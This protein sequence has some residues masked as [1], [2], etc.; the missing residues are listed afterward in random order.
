MCIVRMIWNFYRFV[1]S[2]FNSSMTF[3][4]VSKSYT[5]R[6]RPLSN[7]ECNRAVPILGTLLFLL[8]S[9]YTDIC[10][11]LSIRLKC[12]LTI[13]KVR[14]NTSKWRICGSVNISL[15]R[16]TFL[17]EIREWWNLSVLWTV[18]GNMFVH[19]C[20]IDAFVVISVARTSFCHLALDSAAFT[21]LHTSKL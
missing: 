3:S 18:F 1:T 2:L 11:F 15:K 8:Y 13:C 21:L 9:N 4:I 6:Y 17:W 19:V 5:F 12:A 16:D 7:Q 14:N 20:R 10:P